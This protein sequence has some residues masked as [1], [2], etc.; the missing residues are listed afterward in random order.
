MSYLETEEIMKKWHGI[1]EIHELEAKNE[2]RDKV[3]KQTNKQMKKKYK[4][5]VIGDSHA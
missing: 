4:V 5:I 1:Q 2:G 3:Q